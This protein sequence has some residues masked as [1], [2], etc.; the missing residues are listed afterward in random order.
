MASTHTPFEKLTPIHPNRRITLETGATPIAPRLIDLFVP[1]GFGQRALVVAPPKAGKTTIL[2]QIA[3][4]IQQ[5]YPEAHLFLCLVDERPEE[6][7]EW[8]MEV[9]GPNVKTYASS[10]DQHLSKH[11]RIVERAL[12]D[13]RR[14][15]E[16]GHDVIILL[17]SLT[18]LARAHNLSSEMWSGPRNQRGG[19]GSRT[20]SGGLDVHA[21][22]VGRRVFGAARALEE[23]SSLTIIAS[24]L[25]ETG[26][27]LDEVVYEE[28]KGTGNLEVRLSRELADRRVFPAIDVSASSTRQEERLLSPNELRAMAIVRRKMADLPRLSGS[29]QVV[30]LFEKT[31]SN[32]QLVEAIVK[33][34]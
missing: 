11:G 28:F 27:R 5:N 22:E 34:G 12:Q 31:R 32:T 14:E 7:T 16:Q 21:L 13:A 3:A 1:L 26:S 17:D 9:Q 29:E 20:L 18:R 15:V 19:Y 33:Q 2:R 8:R 24:C 23:G 25:V 10:F 4:S 6:V 30:N